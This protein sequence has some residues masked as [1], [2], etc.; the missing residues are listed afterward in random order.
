MRNSF[1]RLLI[2]FVYLLALWLPTLGAHAQIKP[3][4]SVKVPPVYLGLDAQ[5]VAV[6]DN[7]PGRPPVYRWTSLDT[8]KARINSHGLLTPLKAASVKILVEATLEDGTRLQTAVDVSIQ[9]PKLVIEPTNKALF[10]GGTRRYETYV[11]YPD[12][13]KNTLISGASWS[14]A[15]PQVIQITAQ[16]VATGLLI[17][18]STDIHAALKYHNYTLNALHT[19]AVSPVPSLR[20]SVDNDGIPVNTRRT[21]HASLSQTEGFAWSVA[22]ESSNP[23]IIATGFPTPKSN[24]LDNDILALGEGKARIRVV[25]T[26]PDLPQKLSA[27]VNLQAYSPDTTSI[28]I[29]PASIRLTSDSPSQQLTAEGVGYEGEVVWESTNPDIV[30]DANGVVTSHTD[31]SVSALIFARFANPDIKHR[32]GQALA[33]HADLQSDIFDL[34]TD[35]IMDGPEYTYNDPNQPASVTMTLR[36]SS[37][38]NN[39]PPV[40]SVISTEISSMVIDELEH[41][42]ANDKLILRGRMATLTEVY[43]NLSIHIGQPEMQRLKALNLSTSGLTEIEYR[44]ANSIPVACS[45]EGELTLDTSLSFND[46]IEFAIDVD[47]G[48]FNGFSATGHAMVELLADPSVPALD[49]EAS[50]SLEYGC[51]LYSPNFAIMGIPIYGVVT[52]V[53]QIHIGASASLAL[54]ASMPLTGSLALPLSSLQ[55]T[56]AGSLRYD[57]VTGAES[58]FQSNPPRYTITPR[59][60]SVVHTIG[61]TATME[62]AGEAG[63]LWAA[64]P[65]PIPV[66]PGSTG[67]LPVDI[68]RY[69]PKFPYIG[70]SLPTWNDVALAH[71][72]A[73]LL[74]MKAGQKLSM[75]PAA[76]L[77][78]THENY[79]GPKQE[80][81]FKIDLHSITNAQPG[82][83]VVKVLKLLGAV[84]DP[85]EFQITD[86]TPSYPALDRQ[87]TTA[88]FQEASLD[89]HTIYQGNGSINGYPKKAKLSFELLPTHLETLISQ[90]P[91]AN[92]SRLKILGEHNQSGHWEV[93]HDYPYDEGIANVDVIPPRVGSWQIR[94]YLYR[95][96]EV[97]WS[98]VANRPAAS[99]RFPLE[100]VAMPG[101][102]TNP[103]HISVTVIPDTTG[104]PPLELTNPT[105]NVMNITFQGTTAWI[106]AMPPISLVANE[107]KAVLVPVSCE[108][109][110]EGFKETGNLRLLDQ[111]NGQLLANIPVTLTCSAFMVQPAAFSVRAYDGESR[112]T[113][114]LVSPIHNTPM[115]FTATSDSADLVVT[116]S[117][118]ENGVA[119]NLLA[120]KTCND[121]G[122][123]D[124]EITVTATNIGGIPN[125]TAVQ[126]VPLVAT[127]LEPSES[128][129]DPHISTFDRKKYD[130]QGMGEY[131]MTRADN[132]GEFEVQVR[133]AAL[134]T[135]AAINKAIAMRLAPDQIVSIYAD[136]LAEGGHRVHINRELTHLAIAETQQLGTA[137][138]ITRQTSNI[139]IVKWNN[140]ARVKVRLRGSHT[141]YLDLG[142]KPPANSAGQLQGLLGNFN[143]DPTDDITQR[144][145][146]IETE[147]SFNGFYNCVLHPNCFAYGPQSWLIRTT[148]ES[149][150]DYTQGQNPTS[151]MP[152][153]G[154][155]FPQGAV[156]PEEIPPEITQ[157]CENA[158][159][160]ELH[161]EDCKLDY[162]L[163][164][165]DS[166]IDSAVDVSMTELPEMP[167]EYPKNCLAIK[168]S[169]VTESGLYW[170]N[171]DILGLAPP[172]EVYCD[173]TTASG[174]WTL[175]L[176]EN[177]IPIK[178]KNDGN[179]CESA[180]L[181]LF[182]PHS[183]D[184]FAAGRD[185]LTSIDR[186]G[187]AGPLGVVYVGPAETVNYEYQPFNS[188]NPV[189]NGK[190]GLA[191]YPQWWISDSTNIS[192]PVVLN[193][194]ICGPNLDEDCSPND[195]YLQ[196]FYDANG[197]AE[198]YS[199]SPA[200]QIS[201]S[202]YL[203][204]HHDD[205]NII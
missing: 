189:F 26:S 176:I 31:K 199:L 161:M 118:L 129:G 171:P 14:S 53:P 163:T 150:F 112:L 95:N 127:C 37:F 68:G 156:F 97:F 71:F 141:L 83:Y 76:L 198:G 201:Y 3:T 104:T 202:D 186:T 191:A 187:K 177:G 126:T 137:G 197:N 65:G 164:Q 138:H 182:Q 114:G 133:Q 159:V 27:E 140:G 136:A 116:M 39:L 179:S 158:G 63:I 181:I 48:R 86:V 82:G 108:G 178:N 113:G 200:S 10:V 149:L 33:I 100:V 49:V 121:V 11:V 70:G 34:P 59:G 165:D 120:T 73:P 69:L 147:Q 50:A 36:A 128:T 151:F 17:N 44:Q 72:S 92:W 93:L 4:L 166:F 35:I 155:T 205:V 148:Q 180:G 107:T 167:G 23:A 204:M 54:E 125:K 154:T 47:E 174:G 87:Q 135:R 160:D 188:S 67:P 41:Q 91:L 96:D 46:D 131:V 74:D 2:A 85:D 139:Y 29:L 5:L 117:P 61:M 19:Q 1:S 190:F 142:I 15:N 42:P 173:M 103:R 58:E 24:G 134:N 20:L 13:H 146:T 32:P 18:R 172:I 77:P 157:R 30:I 8:T 183:K 75:T 57:R 79:L 22:W 52:L 78:E 94:A 184:A 90:E 124:H 99:T 143:G 25:L 62:T 102:S 194:N 66:A 80:N 192:D 203:C 105:S 123:Y 153:P 40:G 6:V 110:L 84:G 9:L 185:Y 38:G 169:G 145:P 122:I 89:T 16:G 28:R 21:L 144:D 56:M 170:I 12:I 106:G 88:K 130:L 162:F 132:A 111:T 109:K 98:M 7:Y 196:I 43:R 60:F 168:A 115:D 193:A 51:S 101:L 195:T 152:A 45:G 55:Q 175:K 119:Y 64:V 81:Y